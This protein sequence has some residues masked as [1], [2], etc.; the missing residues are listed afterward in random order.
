MARR[1]GCDVRQ[2]SFEQAEA[3]PVARIGKCEQ[4][5]NAAVTA[6]L[7]STRHL[8]PGLVVAPW[9][10]EG[11]KCEALLLSVAVA[12]DAAAFFGAVLHAWPR[13]SR[14]ETKEYLWNH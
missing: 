8:R 14:S 1:K 9:S 4:Q 5:F 11:S 10:A 7:V 12:V 13:W 6:T 2:R 3:K